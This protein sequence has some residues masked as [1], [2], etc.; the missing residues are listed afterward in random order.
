MLVV[1]PR[2]EFPAILKRV[3]LIVEPTWKA[4]MILQGLK[5]RFRE[6]IVI[7]TLSAINNFAVLYQRMGELPKAEGLLRDL[8]TTRLAKHGPQHLQVANS[9][10]N[11][12]TTLSRQHRYDESIALHKRARMTYQSI[13]QEDNYLVDVPLLSIAYAQLKL[14][15]FEAAQ[16][17]A[18]EA[19]LRFQAHAPGTIYEGVAHCLVALGLQAQGLT[20]QAERSFVDAHEILKLGRV[21]EP[22]ATLCK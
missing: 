11:L 22:Y 8:L 7:R 14:Q 20:H 16:T 4:R 9:Q 18:G 6:R 10:Q 12:A 1:V 17:S 19:L 3:S 15:Q 13:L 2:K 21:G 5:L